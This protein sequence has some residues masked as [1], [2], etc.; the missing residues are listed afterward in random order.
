MACPLSD[1]TG[2]HRQLVRYLARKAGKEVR[3]ELVGDHLAVDRLVLDG[4]SDPLR[5]LLV[6]A[7]DHG[8]EAPAERVAAGKAPT[9]TLSLHASVEQ[10]RLCLVVEDDGRGVDWDAVRAA[11]IRRR[12]PPDAATRPGRAR[13]AARPAVQPGLQH[14]SF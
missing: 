4:L 8:V 7:I 13:L 11:A 12:A 14:R 2:T 1:I 5:H 6:N 10:A 9:A 3:F